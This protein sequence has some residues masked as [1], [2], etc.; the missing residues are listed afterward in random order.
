VIHL[1]PYD[2]GNTQV[3]PGND[4]CTI[5]DSRDDGNTQYPNWNGQCATPRCK[6][7]GKC[8]IDATN[9]GSPCVP[10][11]GRATGG[12]N[13]VF[14]GAPNW[15]GIVPECV[16]YTCGDKPG[17][18]GHCIQRN[19]AGGRTHFCENSDNDLCTYDWCDG[20]G[21][22]KDHEWKEGRSAEGV[23]V[24]DH[25]DPATG[26]WSYTRNGDACCG[27][28]EINTGE[29][30]EPGLS[31]AD[32]LC[33][34]SCY[35][36][37]KCDDNN[38]CTDE[39]CTTG[40]SCTRTF[41]PNNAPKCPPLDTT[42]PDNLCKMTICAQ[43]TDPAVIAA[44]QVVADPSKEGAV[45][46]PADADAPC[47]QYVC[48]SGVCSSEPASL[49]LPCQDS[50]VPARDTWPACTKYVCAAST[51]GSTGQCVPVPDTT[52]ACDDDDLCTTNACADVNGVGTCVVTT[53]TS[54]APNPNSCIAPPV[55]D[56]RTGNCLSLPLNG[57]P[58]DRPG[59]Y[60]PQR[61]DDSCSN[62]I[63]I[64]GACLLSA[65]DCPCGNGRLDL[66]ETCD[67]SMNGYEHCCAI[68]CTG[69][70]C[71]NG[72][73]DQGEQCDFGLEAQIGCC[74]SSCMGC[75]CGNGQI[76]EGEQ[77]DPAIPED[78]ECCSAQCK[79]CNAQSNFNRVAASAA[80]GAGVLIVAMVAA[81]GVAV[82]MSSSAAV[83]AASS[84]D[85]SAG[86]V[87]ENPLFKNQA[88]VANPLYS[89]AL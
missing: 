50:S 13:E 51:D 19:L 26:L 24:E 71:G 76:D 18:Y 35:L 65:D 15:P 10:I 21:M 89:N 66:G 75:L 31:G 67:W 80:I 77:C 14:V 5:D 39:T 59:D 85:A 60:E 29:E 74:N 83:A 16:Y 37:A 47:T 46:R 87:K 78:A 3:F 40:G 28:G 32:S 23:C 45:C 64:E 42:V 55:C 62:F 73:I 38:V 2:S 7:N 25:C 8:G 70:L 36:Q 27:N 33:C 72:K 79:G 84:G 34:I 12:Y 63:C 88:S 20:L 49:N 4:F 6:E 48:R 17:E 86:V 9:F 69:C 1:I 11:D 81:A 30:C 54:C 43:S 44:C 22:C 61:P 41:N 56:P 52:L 53:T 57:A 58:C 82:A 68:N